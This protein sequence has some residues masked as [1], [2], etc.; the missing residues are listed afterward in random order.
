MTQMCSNIKIVNYNFNL[1][2]Q[3]DITNF[4]TSKIKN[5]IQKLNFK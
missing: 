2:H 5:H 1:S 4:I 3:I